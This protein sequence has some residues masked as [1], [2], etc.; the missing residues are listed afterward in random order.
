M[1]K[2]VLINPSYASTYGSAKA[3]ITTP[4]YPTLGLA[5]I[6]ATAE[7]KGHSVEILDL[8]HQPYD[9]AAVRRFI[10]ESRP[11]VVG[12]T[13]TSPLMNQLRDISCLIKDISS[14]IVTIGGGAHPSALPIETMRES[15]LDYVAYGE[16]DF[17]FVDILDGKAPA[18]IP[19]ICYRRGDEVLKTAPRTLLEYLDDLPMPAWHLYG[20]DTYQDR[21]SRMIVKRPPA[22]M[23]EFSRGCVFKCDFCGSKNTMGLGYRKKSP[24]RCAEEMAHL[25]RLGYREAILAD[26]IF[27]SDHDWAVAVCEAFI[28]RDVKMAWTCTNGIRVDSAKDDLFSVMKRAGCYRVHFGFESGNDDVLKAFG[29]GGRATLEQ[30]LKAVQGARRAGM[31]TFGMFMVGLSADSEASMQDTIDYAARSGVDMMRFGVTVPVPGTPMFE[32]LRRTGHIRSYDWDLYNVYNTRPIFDHPTLSWDTIE[33]YYQKAYR[34]AFLKNPRFIA[35]R[36]VRGITTGE[37]LWDVYYFFKFMTLNMDSEA[38]AVEYRYRDTWPTYNFNEG[39]IR[40]IEVQQA[41][42]K[43]WRLSP[44]H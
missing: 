22:A 44:A 33:H 4:V 23:V 34:D 2:V 31:D 12:I 38:S 19:G 9:A 11:D 3:S 37:F 13:A 18:S 8:S 20:I 7:A 29:K 5:T 25:Y 1:A 36:F 42:Q 26:D 39:P 24:E 28:K 14:D 15:M 35:R 10:S 41:K 21:M 40:P 27:T 32:Q 6:A 43:S 30:G 16:A 17:T